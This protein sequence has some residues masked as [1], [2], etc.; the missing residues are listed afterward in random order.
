MT[1]LIYA[2]QQPAFRGGGSPPAPTAEIWVGIGDSYTVGTTVRGGGDTDWPNSFQWRTTQVPT[3]INSDITPLDQPIPPDGTSYLSYLEYFIK[4][5]AAATSI[6]IIIVP[7]GW[8]GTKMVGSGN[9]WGLGNSLY[10]MAI[11]RTNAAIAA[12]LIA[13]PG[14]QFAGFIHWMGANDANDGVSRAAYSSALSATV[15]GYKTR[16]FKNGVNGATVGDV[17]YIC[18]GLLPEFPLGNQVEY[19]M[20]DIMAA[21][22]GGKYVP[23]AEGF[24]A[25]DN[26]HPNN[27]GARQHGIDCANILTDIAAPVITFPTAMSVYSGQT[28]LRELK[29]DKYTYWT[30]TGTDAAL[31]EVF[32]KTDGPSGI[33]ARRTR[34]YLRPVSGGNLGAAGTYNITIN[35]EGGNGVVATQP[36]AIT[37][38]AAYGNDPGPATVTYIGAGSVAVPNVTGTYIIPNVAF[39]AGL[40][41]LTLMPGGATSAFTAVK[42]GGTV[43]TKVAN[44]SS[45]DLYDIWS[46]PIAEAG[47]YDIELTFTG[48]LQSLN[49]IINVLNSTAAAASSFVSVNAGFRNSPQETPSITVPANGLAVGT[50]NAQGANGR[51]PLSGVTTLSSNE[52][53]APYQWAGYR[54]STGTLGFN[55]SGGA[56]M[57]M[58]AVAYARAT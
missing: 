24:N 13:Y 54:T 53:T 33:E 19:A 35:A 45:G 8:N 51:T 2:A 41:L 16:V 44:T 30:I 5:R 28:F 22:T 7:M 6:P 50:W 55:H 27:A 29:S 42:V 21:T 4:T 14:A 49:Y 15:A 48:T 47:S 1:A 12:A 3:G 10:E 18:G 20:Q 23:L 46:I 39:G 17:P 56:F 9:S 25:G 36:L 32:A 26:L 52:S 31:F 40:D 34:W 58:V 57:G 38:V 43:G 11:T 37:S